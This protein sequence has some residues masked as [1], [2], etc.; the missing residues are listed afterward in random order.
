ML[1]HRG[2]RND[3]QVIKNF[4]D[5]PGGWIPKAHQMQLGRVRP[6]VI[7]NGVGQSIVLVCAGLSS[8]EQRRRRCRLVPPAAD[9]VFIVGHHGVLEGG[10][11]FAPGCPGPS[12]AGRDCRGRWRSRGAV[13]APRRG[14]RRGRPRLPGPAIRRART[15]RGP[16]PWRGEDGSCRPVPRRAS[17]GLI[18][19]HPAAQP[20]PERLARS[21]PIRRRPGGGGQHADPV[22]EK[23]G[24]G[25]GRARRSDP[26]IGWAPTKTSRAVGCDSTAST[27]CRFVL[28]A[29]VTRAEPGRPRR[30]PD[31]VGESG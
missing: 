19:K 1:D 22:R 6:R 24:A 23:P 31:V 5:P 26:A 4:N 27:I 7:G 15:R 3:V 9:R 29:S 25:M 30:P 2:S 8:F 20:A 12:A 16:R 13:S 10:D 11:P 28:P 21:K 14:C 17:L 18:S